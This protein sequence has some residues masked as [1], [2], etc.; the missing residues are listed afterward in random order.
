MLAKRN[1]QLP[2]WSN[3]ELE[4]YVQVAL[5]GE[6]V[7]PSTRPR[8]L[9]VLTR[10]PFPRLQMVQVRDCEGNAM[11]LLTVGGDK[12]V[13]LGKGLFQSRLI[14]SATIDCVVKLTKRS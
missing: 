10:Q 1:K 12:Q 11:Q 3:P 6:V 8:L 9:R 14:G 2:L 13:N 5:Y 4:C 7:V